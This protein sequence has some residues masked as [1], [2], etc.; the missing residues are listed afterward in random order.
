MT[1]NEKLTVTG[2]TKYITQNSDFFT[3]WG[4]GTVYS[5]L[6]ICKCCI[7]GIM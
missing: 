3:K 1:M 5:Y 4:E 7:N 6:I 2:L